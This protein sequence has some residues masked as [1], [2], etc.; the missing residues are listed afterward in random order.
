MFNYNY[1]P[2]SSEELECCLN[3]E[4]LVNIFFKQTSRRR[5]GWLLEATP[6][7][8][9]FPPMS[10]QSCCMTLTSFS[11]W[12]SPAV[13]ESPFHSIQTEMDGIQVNSII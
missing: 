13:T 4:N 11:T 2:L 3:Y 12:E 5:L 7:I 6:P 1:I 9:H 8:A 10:S